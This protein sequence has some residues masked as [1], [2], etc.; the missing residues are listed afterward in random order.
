[1]KYLLDSDAVN[2][3]YDDQREPYHEAIHAHISKL[4]DE[5][6]LQTSVI[7]LYEL[8][9]SCCNAPQ[10]KKQR[11]RDTINAILQD[12][13]AIL[14]VEQQTAP[15]YGEL[16][17]RLKYEKRLGRKAMRMHNIDIILASTA[18][19]TSSVLIGM[20]RIY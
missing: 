17:F 4:N 5:D 13:D 16:K 1:M 8:E 7:V 2:I 6:L 19:S 10:E 12:F 20:D 11:I 9:Y 3:L 14:P 18:I 15:I